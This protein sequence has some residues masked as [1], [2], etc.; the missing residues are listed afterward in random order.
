MSS[1]YQPN[2]SVDDMKSKKQSSK[3]TLSDITKPS[4]RADKPTATPAPQLV[5]PKRSVIVPVVSA[6]ES[7]SPAEPAKTGAEPEASTDKT[8]SAGGLPKL[9]VAPPVSP[10]SES[11]T[12]Q[13]PVIAHHAP[14]AS[15]SQ[16]G[17]HQGAP[18]EPP[19]TPPAKTSPVLEGRN[20]STVANDA[21]DLDPASSTQDPNIRKALEDAKRQEQIQSYIEEGKFF[22]PINAVARKRSVRVTIG[23]TFLELLLGVALINFMLDAGLISLLEKIPHTNFFGLH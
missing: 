18:A 21:T 6:Y 11:K 5:I 15:A 3:Q 20:A 22:V 23:L 8:P 9:Q 7:V 13:A 19:A 4:K 17:L 12:A 2:G 14:A 10:P 16:S 1:A